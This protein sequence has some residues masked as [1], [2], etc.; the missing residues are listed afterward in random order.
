MH[1]FSPKSNMINCIFASIFSVLCIGKLLVSEDY[2]EIDPNARVMWKLAESDNEQ[3]I[4]DLLKEHP[5]WITHKYIGDDTLLHL[6]AQRRFTKLIRFL[7]TANKIDVNS[8]NNLSNSA[9]TLA[10][11]N[12]DILQMQMLIQCGAIVN[13]K[14]NTE[15]VFILGDSPLHH[16]ID[17]GSE[18]AVAFLLKN[19]ASVNDGLQDT[20]L[21]RA[22]SSGRIGMVS[23]LVEAG[24]K[25]SPVNLSLFI[26]AGNLPDPAI[27]ILLMEKGNL[28][29]TKQGEVGPLLMHLYSRSGNVALIEYLLSKKADINATDSEGSPPLLYAITEGHFQAVQYLLEHHADSTIINSKG[30]SVLHCAAIH[31]DPKLLQL[32]LTFSK[33]HLNARESEKGSTPL[34]LAIWSHSVESVE[35][36]IEQ[37]VDLNIRDHAGRTPLM[38]AARLNLPAIIDKLLNAG[39][40]VSLTQADR[41][42]ALHEAVMSGGFEAVKVLGN[43]Y[44]DL[45][46]LLISNGDSLL[47]LAIYT[48]N[49]DICEWLIKNGLDKN[50]KNHEGKTP[51]DLAK[52]LHAEQIELSLR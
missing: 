34:H 50:M 35:V 33:K 15:D 52:E 30:I 47:H 11:G 12:A 13:R 46:K 31:R 3:G 27:A 48:K 20:P 22:V 21:K 16:A 44:A 28:S 4:L 5:D 37:K 42:T 24:A 6:A 7:L 9:L 8:L 17:S 18:A 38:L 49:K 2:L 51:L 1:L 36:L 25:I 29:F 45:N 23:L 41:G 43:K 26:S 19:H 10:S 39:A 40:D 32:L 14:I